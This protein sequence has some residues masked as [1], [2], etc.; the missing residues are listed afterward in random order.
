MIKAHFLGGLHH[1]VFEMGW[2]LCGADL[3]SEILKKRKAHKFNPPIAGAASTPHAEQ[4]ALVWISVSASA[5][6]WKMLRII[7]R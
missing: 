7:S 6:E 1:D 3:L 2:T 5:S 4:I